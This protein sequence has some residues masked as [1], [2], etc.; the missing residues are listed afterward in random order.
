MIT[1]QAHSI[2][3]AKLLAFE[4]LTKTVTMTETNVCICC[5]IKCLGKHGMAVLQL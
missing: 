2:Q 4:T 5:H 3:A 1:I